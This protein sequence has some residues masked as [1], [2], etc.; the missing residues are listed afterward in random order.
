M[1][2]HHSPPPRET[3]DTKNTKKARQSTSPT[4][5]RYA[6]LSADEDDEEMIEFSPVSADSPVTDAENKIKALSV[7]RTKPGTQHE[8]EGTGQGK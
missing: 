5:N 3:L 4:T 2:V 8:S 1:V 7:Q 6:A